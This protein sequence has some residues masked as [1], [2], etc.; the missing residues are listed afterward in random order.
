MRTDRDRTVRAGTIALTNLSQDHK[1]KELIGKFAMKDLVYKLPGGS[2]PSV[3]H[4]DTTIIAVLNTIRALVDGNPDNGRH[5]RDSAGI[6]RITT[7]NRK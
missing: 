3:H 5:L 4:S 1:N 6:E 2:D 7:I